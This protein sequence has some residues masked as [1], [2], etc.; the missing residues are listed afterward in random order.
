MP[1]TYTTDGACFQS[2]DKMM[3]TKEILTLQFGHYANHVGS[4][5]WNLQVTNSQISINCL[6]I[7]LIFQETNFSY[8]S[9]NPSEV[10][11]DILFREGRDDKNVSQQALI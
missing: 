11:V 5:W 1:I 9:N 3:D 6:V 2:L 10:N 8:D 4:H 7:S